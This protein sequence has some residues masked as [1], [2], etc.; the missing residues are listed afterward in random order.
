M[1]T[2]PWEK[3]RIY[4]DYAAAT[5]LRREAWAAMK[6]FWQNDYANP[7]AIHAE[8]VKARRA[9]EEAREKVARTLRVR[10]TDIV[11]TSGG[12]E[13]NN[14]ALRGSV[15]AMRRSGLSAADIEIISTKVEHPSILKTLE[16]LA[17]D[18]CVITY[19]PVGEDGL[20]VTETFAKMLSPRTRLISIAYANSETGVVQDITKLS[21]VVK[22]FARENGLDISFHID[23]SQAP[24]WLPCALD[25]LGVDLMTLDAGKCE[26]PKG[27]GI[28]VRR[29]KAEL[30]AAAFGGS[31]EQGLR[32]GTE[33]AALIA[34]A[35]VAIELAQQEAEKTAHRVAKL[36][37]RWVRRLSAIDGVVV[38]GSLKHRLPNNVNISIPGY[39]SEFAVITLD[40]F[41][42]AASTKSAC[43]GSGS[44]RSEVVFAMTADPVRSASTIRFTL[45]PHTSWRDLKKTTGILENFLK[46]MRPHTFDR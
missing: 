29:P 10:A 18:G 42:I 30:S 38:N 45:S 1:I 4:L 21:R 40:R 8:G 9:V 43:A 46:E 5:P 19:A 22:A 11:F 27:V 14:L 13:S 7:S 36:R 16:A 24:L 12:T 28:L 33:P 39:D 6:P 37:D 25:A 15:L 31:Q 3:K 44:G 35:A 34:G 41:G 20:V 2:W 32:P 23:A 26:G 17:Q